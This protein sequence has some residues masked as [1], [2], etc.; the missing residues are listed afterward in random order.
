MQ[1]DEVLWAVVRGPR[2]SKLGPI[3]FLSIARFPLALAE[4]QVDQ[5][6]H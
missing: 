1:Q 3:P 2:S 4:N 5:R 6:T